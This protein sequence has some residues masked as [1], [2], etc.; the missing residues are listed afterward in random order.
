MAWLTVAHTDL[1]RGAESRLTSD[2]GSG[3]TLRIRP[4]AKKGKDG[5]SSGPQFG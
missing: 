5:P 4:K 1:T 3:N 2:A